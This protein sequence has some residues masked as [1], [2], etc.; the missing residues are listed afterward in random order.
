MAES[1]REGWLVPAETSGPHERRR[2][3]IVFEKRSGSL[4][5][6]CWEIIYRRDRE[7]D[8]HRGAV[9]DWSM[10][11]WQLLTLELWMQIFMMAAA[12]TQ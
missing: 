6:W 5:V 9:Q 4:N 1:Y 3:R 2:S 12:T 10:Q 11:I 7:V 8:E